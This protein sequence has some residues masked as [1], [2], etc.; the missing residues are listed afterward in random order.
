MDQ[1]E[2]E[3]LVSE[4]ASEREIASRFGVG[5]T[6]VRRW[7]ARYGLAT[8][9]AQRLR[10]VPG[11]GADGKYLELPC[12]RHGV[13]TFVVRSDGGGRRCLKCR[14]DAVSRRRRRV[15]RILVE[16]AGGACRLCGYDR[17]VAALQFHHV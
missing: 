14:S 8:V 6:T 3:A 11:V 15:K 4:G 13:T 12:R 17:C 7:L 9:R 1:D 5:H 16:E 2:L 10:A